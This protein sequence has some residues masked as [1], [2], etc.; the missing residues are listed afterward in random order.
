MMEFSVA[1]LFFVQRLVIMI[2][3]QRV[4]E[5]TALERGLRSQFT[6]EGYLE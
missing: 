5:N 6:V 4:A 3:V 2:D 1:A